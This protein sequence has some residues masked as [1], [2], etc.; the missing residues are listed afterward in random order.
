MPPV[1]PEGPMPLYTR[2]G[3]CLCTPGGAHASEHPEEPT[4]LYTQRSLCFCTPRG[5]Y[6]CLPEHPFISTLPEQLPNRFNVSLNVHPARQITIGPI[7]LLCALS[8]ALFLGTKRL[9][10]P[11]WPRNERVSGGGPPCHPLSVGCH[12]QFEYEL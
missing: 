9:L 4:P 6:A 3:P 2:R 10:Q 11:L 1:H 5:A 12:N 7:D 8:P